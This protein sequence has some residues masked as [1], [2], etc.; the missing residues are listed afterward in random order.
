MASVGTIH[1]CLYL[2]TP[3]QTPGGHQRQNLN[4]SYHR[5]VLLFSS[6][7]C[8][9]KLEGQRDLRRVQVLFNGVPSLSCSASPSTYIARKNRQP[10]WE[11]RLLMGLCHLAYRPRKLGK[12]VANLAV[13]TEKF[14]SIFLVFPFFSIVFSFLLLSIQKLTYVVFLCLLGLWMDGNWAKTIKPRQRDFPG[15]VSSSWCANVSAVATYKLFFVSAL[16]RRTRTFLHNCPFAPVAS[17]LGFYWGCSRS[18]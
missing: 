18:S 2:Q 11:V 3:Q 17:F 15:T 9:Y 16:I 12:Q 6:Q 8:I 7:H 1:C 10:V 13:Y 5:N 4:H 14:F